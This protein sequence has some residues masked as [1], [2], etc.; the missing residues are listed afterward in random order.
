MKPSFT[1][2][3][4]ARLAMAALFLASLDSAHA[5]AEADILIAFDNSYF[6]GTGGIDNAEVLTANSVAASNFINDQSGTG[7]R[8]KIVGYHPTYNQGGRSDLPGYIG[9]ILNYGDGEL[10]DVSAAADAAGAD[11]I[12]Y[13][14]QPNQWNTSA[15]NAQQPGR[16]AAYTPA[17]FWNNVVA[18]ES[19]GHNYGVAHEEGRVNPTTIMMHNYCGGGSQPFFSNPNIWLHGTKLVGGMDGCTVVGWGDGAYHIS[20][21]AQAVSDRV[22]RI[23]YGSK[24]SPLVHRWQFN[25]AAGP[26]PAGTTVASSVGSGAL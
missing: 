17:S 14:C 25:Q 13:I 4:P 3:C 12:A 6:D 1:R 7:A 19:G 26:A 22:A 16:V 15:A 9:W 10:N 18:H 21:T 20:T 23:N 8:M 5:A 11:L 2:S 24:L